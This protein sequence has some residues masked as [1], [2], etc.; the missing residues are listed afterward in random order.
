MRARLIT[1]Q[2]RYRGVL[3]RH[4]TQH[5]VGSVRQHLGDL[6]SGWSQ[7]EPLG[8]L[9]VRMGLRK[10]AAWLGLVEHDGDDLTYEE[11]PP[12]VAYAE[13]DTLLS[14][15]EPETPPAAGAGFQIA[16]IKAQN[17][18]DAHTIGEYF[19]QDIPVLINLDDMTAADAKRIVDFASGL[20][21]GRKGDI[22]RVSSRV[23]LLMPRQFDILKESGTLNDKEF[24]NQA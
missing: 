14:E 10:T 2:W 15:E 16:S 23:F 12:A 1:G 20:I 5:D 8:Q 6:V 22:E 17:F 24:F 11:T 9:E 4:S 7:R 18:G 21:F 3:L 19:R 13:D